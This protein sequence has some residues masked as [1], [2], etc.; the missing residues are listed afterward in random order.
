MSTEACMV[1]APN[2]TQSRYRCPFMVKAGMATN[3]YNPSR[4]R[5]RLPGVSWLLSKTMCLGFHGRPCLKRKKAGVLLTLGVCTCTHMCLHTRAHHTHCND[6]KITVSV[7]RKTPIPHLL[8][9]QG[10]YSSV[11][12]MLVTL[13][14]SKLF[15]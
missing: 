7:N 15:Y 4:E 6:I 5:R 10:S 9:H 3:A 13:M 12:K 2:W 8:S 11:R 14:L 1:I